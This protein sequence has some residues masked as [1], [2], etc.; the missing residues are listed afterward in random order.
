M[1]DFKPSLGYLALSNKVDI[2]PM[3]LEGTH[4]ALPKGSFLPQKR[5]IAAHVGPV[6]RYDELRKATEGMS[7]SDAYREAS[8]LVEQAVRKLAPEGSVN[9]MGA[10]PPTGG[11]LTAASVMV[12]T[13]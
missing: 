6:L 12:E 10:V 5:E 3:Y 11:R 2:L 1:V 13:E 8:H 4:D 9:R 7:R